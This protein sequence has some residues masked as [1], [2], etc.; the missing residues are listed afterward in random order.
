MAPHSGPFFNQGR[1]WARH[2]PHSGM[3]QPET[4]DIE[5]FRTLVTATGRDPGV[6]ALALHPDGNV[7]VT[8][9][10]GTAFY[11]RADWLPRFFRHLERGFFDPVTRRPDGLEQTAELGPEDA[12]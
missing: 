9:P 3:D 2:L 11:P 10:R 5:A 12:D 7:R 1:T 8:G 4:A 6:F